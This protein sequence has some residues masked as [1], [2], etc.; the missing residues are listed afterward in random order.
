LEE[1]DPYVT[2]NSNNN[3]QASISWPDQGLAEVWPRD[4]TIKL[5]KIYYVRIVGVH[6][7]PLLGIQLQFTNGI[8]SPM[9]SCIDLESEE[10]K[11]KVVIVACDTDFSKFDVGKVGFLIQNEKEYLAM[12]VWD[13]SNKL[14]NTTTFWTGP[15]IEQVKIVVKEIPDRQGIIGLHADTSDK[16]GIS[17][18]GF[19]TW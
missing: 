4:K 8:R 1:Q 18:L 15:Q 9:V 11:D 6:E 13:R 2:E 5:Q 16:S 10:Y 14:I 19:V 3:G 17:R 7:A 12:K